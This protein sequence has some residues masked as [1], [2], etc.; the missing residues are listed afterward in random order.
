MN[1]KKLIPIFAGG[2]IVILVIALIIIFIPSGGKPITGARKAI[3]LC[4]ANDFQ[5]SEGE[6]DFND[7]ED[8][9][10]NSETPRWI[11]GNQTN[12][13]GGIDNH[14][15]GRN[16]TEGVLQLIAQLDGYVNMEFIFNWTKYYPLYEFAIYNLSA[17]VNIT[18]NSWIPTTIINLTGAGA[19]IGL[20]WLN[21]SNDVVRTDWSKGIFETNKGWTFLNVTGIADS[22]T[23]NKI[24]QLHLVLAV[25]GNMTGTD[26]VLFDDL[27]VERWISVN[28]TN[29]INPIPVPGKIDTDGFPAQAL[30]VYWILR[31]HG[32]SDENIF[33]MLYHKNDAIIDIRANDGI[34]NDLTG[35]VIDVEDDD[36][37]ASR[38]QQELNI[39]I[40]GS[41]ASSIISKDQLIIYMVDHG[42]N[43][44]VGGNN[45]TYHF[46]ADNSYISETEFYNL[47]K[48]IDCES[49]MINIDS[50]YSGNFLNINSNIGQSW[51]NIPKSIL[52]TSS[53]DRFSWY[54][55][56]NNNLDGF[57]GS[58]FF[59]IFWD[60]L[61]QNRTVEDSFEYANNYIPAGQ[62]IP[63]IQIQNP[64]IQDNL[65]IKDTWSFTSD[66]P[67]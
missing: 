37:N 65:G 25:D 61:N 17:W 33:L 27:R 20:R 30:Q 8:A 11:W 67:L 16:G 66:P 29:P 9:N 57:A 39:S 62:N 19:R 40:E 28:V 55:K 7:G 51:Y 42:S 45:A 43:K 46:E 38:F 56:D 48:K 59:Y 64:Q 24:N 49:M 32:Y 18:T 21:S 36:V 34:S 54:W 63:I 26:M 22:S 12:G 5:K 41:F 15:P 1:R 52:I 60:Q 58:W 6:D 23:Q 53:T 14:F 4:S 10:F 3:I 31:N 47:V 50:C 2:I 13:H 44:I 35:A